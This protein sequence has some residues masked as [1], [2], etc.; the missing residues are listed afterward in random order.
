MRFEIVGAGLLAG[1]AV[2]GLARSSGTTWEM[3]PAISGP[4]ADLGMVPSF[5]EEFSGARLRASVWRTA[6]KVDRAG[7]PPASISDR[8]LYGNHEQQ[9]YFDPTFLGAGVQ[10]FAVADGVLTIT[11]A[12]LTPALKERLNDH[13]AKQPTAIRNSALTQAAYSSGLITTRGSFAQTFGYFEIRARWTGGKGLWPA[14]WL[15]PASGDWP[16][17]IDIVEAHGD[18]PYTAYQSL[19]SAAR[20]SRTRT[21]SVPGRT[22]DYH[23]YGLL[24][25]PRALYFYI[26]GRRTALIPTAADTA[27]PMY[28][29]A[30]LAVG[31]SWP[32]NPDSR[33]R[34]PARM[35]IDHIRVWRF[36]DAA[37]DATMK[38]FLR[39]LP[40]RNTQISVIFDFPILGY[41]E[42]VPK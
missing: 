8:S 5:R 26:D 36:K 22:S 4:P 15:L 30:N 18:K 31:G 27:T 33:T 28:L 12:P 2:L 32:G 39:K 7:A 25:T 11:A 16:P 1:M 21:V 35:E 29:L 9:I 17:E 37:N 38:W 40:V 13:L 20:T 42:S 34:M 3:P 24:W 41:I 19:H 6:F 23:L 14:F 10:P